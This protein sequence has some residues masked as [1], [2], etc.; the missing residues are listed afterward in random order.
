[1]EL[2]VIIQWML[3]EIVQCV[4]SWMA[5]VCVCD[6]ATS[7]ELVRSSSSVS[8]EAR[9]ESRKMLKRRKTQIRAGSNNAG[10]IIQ[11][12]HRQHWIES[13]GKTSAVQ[14]AAGHQTA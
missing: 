2:D 7:E 4:S 10:P 13:E 6:L 3:D 5:S 12:Q 8:Y 1:M 11:A 14:T 9:E